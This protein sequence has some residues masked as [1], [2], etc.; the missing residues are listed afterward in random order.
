MIFDI[1]KDAKVAYLNTSVFEAITDTGHLKPEDYLY[2]EQ[3]QALM[4]AVRLIMDF[5]RCIERAG[6]LDYY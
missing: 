4:D 5:E 2:G 3:L 6:K 1:N